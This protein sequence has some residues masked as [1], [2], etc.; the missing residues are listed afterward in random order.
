MSWFKMLARNKLALIGLIIVILLVLSAI[1]APLLAPHSPSEQRLEQALLLPSMEF[2]FGTDDLGRCI[3]S[4]IIF[5]ARLSLLIGITVTAICAVTGVFIGMLAGF[6]GGIVDEVIMRLVDIFLAFPGLILALIIAG[7]MGPGMFN[8]MFALALVG[9]MGY[10]RV[11]R[12]TVLAEKQ[13]EFVE[14]ARALGATDLYL[15]YRHLLPNV[16]APIIV[17][18]SVGIGHTI[19]AAA[20][21]SFLGVG[22]QPPTPVWGLMLKD[23]KGFLQTAPHLTIFPGLAIMVTVLAFNFLGDGLRDLLDPRLKEKRI[24]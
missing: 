18:A 14:T 7:L 13:K 5:G 9:W 24:E 23:G 17:M 10:A 8:V 12:G 21:L 2:P 16:M 4:R 22:V 20:G 3:F 15:M 6:Y 19:L 11:V 1:F